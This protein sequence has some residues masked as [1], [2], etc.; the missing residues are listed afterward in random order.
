MGRRVDG[1]QVPVVAALVEADALLGLPHQLI[2]VFLQLEVLH[3]EPLVGGAGIED[4]LVGGDGEEG[5]GQLPDA[6]LVK[7]AIGNPPLL[8]IP[9]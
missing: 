4:E 2:L 7:I 5:A 8:P 3:I 9:W 1:Q 6:R